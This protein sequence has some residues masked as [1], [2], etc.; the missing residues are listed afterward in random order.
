MYETSF[1]TIGDVS[2]LIFNQTKIFLK[3]QFSFYTRRVVKETSQATVPFPFLTFGTSTSLM[4]IN[5]ILEQKQEPNC[6]NII[7]SE[8]I[9]FQQIHNKANAQVDGSVTFLT[10]IF[11]NKSGLFEEKISSQ[12]HLHD[13]K[14]ITTDKFN[15]PGIT[16][17]FVEPLSQ[18]DVNVALQE[19][20]F[21][22]TRL[23][24]LQTFCLQNHYLKPNCGPGFFFLS[25]NPDLEFRIQTTKR[26]KISCLAVFC[27]HKKLLFF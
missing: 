9:W 15:I 5:I 24:I 2:R 1:N 11:F 16:E 6:S 26:G 22:T 25:R 7:G 4:I 21:F 27:I 14:N 3:S 10:T 17:V 18:T 19:K 12:I 23:E 20:T 13:N 8:R